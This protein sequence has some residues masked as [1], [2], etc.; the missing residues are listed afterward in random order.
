VRAVDDWQDLLRDASR[1]RALGRVD[2]AIAAYE[3]LLTVKPDLADSWYNLGWLQ[4]KARRFED[5]LA[6]YQRAL[7]LHVARPEEVH[8]NLAV[9]HSDHLHQPEAAERELLAALDRNGNYVPA[10]LNLGNLHEDQGDRERAR[11]VYARALAADPDNS[12]ALA[13]L[14]GLS[15]AAKL[16]EALAARLRVAAARPG[17]EPADQAD[18]GFALAGLLDAAGRYDE[19]F[20]TAAAA[21]AASRAAGAVANYDRAETERMVDR[22]IAAF[23]RPALRSGLIEPSPV[24]ICGLFRSGSTLVEQILGRHS[25]VQTSGELD[26]IPALFER[27]EGYP[28]SIAKA[29]SAMVDVWRASYISALPIAPAA[30]REVTDKRPDNFLHVGLI[31]TLFPHAKIIHTRRKPLDNLLSLYFLHLDPSMAYALDLED[32]AH[33][34]RQHERLMAHWRALYRDD[35][36]DVDYDAL[37]RDPRTV[38]EPLLAFLGLEWEDG[39]LDFHR[40]GSIVKTASVWQVR[41]PLHARSSGRWRNYRSQLEPISADFPEDGTGPGR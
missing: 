39:L 5:A 29:D 2:E 11:T 24:F 26:L 8:L 38:L 32:A 6:S 35:I 21:N 3:R 25:H 18:L 31:K 15:H 22:L 37:V 9:I 33:W 27:I 4:R 12:L 20:A 41:Q 34:H 23:N 7:D 16:D 30:D 1:L 14:A 13:R 36:V 17:A 19:A 28:E 40:P 10:L